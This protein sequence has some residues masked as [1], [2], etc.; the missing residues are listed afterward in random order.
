MLGQTIEAKSPARVS[1]L[2]WLVIGLLLV[3]CWAVSQNVHYGMTAVLPV[4]LAAFL[5]R[6][7]P[8]GVIFTIEEDGLVLF[9][10][11]HRLGYDE[12]SAVFLGDQLIHNGHTNLS[13]G[14]ITLTHKHGR[15]YVPAVMNV[16]A[17]EL[18][19]F[20]V[21]K[22]PPPQQKAVPASL[23]EYAS[24]QEEKFGDAKMTYIH[25][26]PQQ[27]Q[28]IKLR[29]LG[30]VAKAIT[31]SG[32]IWFIASAAISEN[33]PGNESFAY[34]L[35]FGFAAICLGIA[36]WML[37]KARRN[38]SP[39]NAERYGPACLI[40]SPTGLGLTQGDLQGKMRW[41]EIS[42]IKNGPASSLSSD[43][44]DSLHLAFAGGQLVIYDIYDHSLTQIASLISKNLKGPS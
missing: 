42:S 25:Q 28:A 17:V 33:K 41:D 38:K 11:D 35:G 18:A 12:I 26:R 23:A 19:Q 9:G 39:V 15:F 27:H 31:L 32:L 6:A 40:I 30:I 37:S 2:V 24:L 36:L 1:V 29:T 8:A 7:I 10:T 3:A 4:L 21:S 13:A 34:W 43:R 5:W 16:S 20:L 44:N 14:P 22:L